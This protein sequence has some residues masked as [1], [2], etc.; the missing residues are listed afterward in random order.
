MGEEQKEEVP[1]SK[2]ADYLLNECRMVLPGIQAL[3]GFQLIVVF[4]QGFDE[5][6]G[7][8]QQHLHLMAIGLVA[9][10]VV[11]VMTPAA[12]HRQIGV[13]EVSDSFIKISNRVLLMSMIPLALGICIDF[14]L[15]SEVISNGWAGGLLAAALFSIFFIFWILLP[16]SRALK[17]M[18]AEGKRSKP[19]HVKREEQHGR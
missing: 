1:L 7:P 9:I 13:W 5:K 6:L 12:Y 18:L 4:N 19:S 16:R 2:A 14:Y 11:F 10:A 8:G 15:I 3:F 17:R